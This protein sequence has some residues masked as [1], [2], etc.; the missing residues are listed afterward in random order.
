MFTENLC[1][2]SKIFYSFSTSHKLVTAPLQKTSGEANG[3]IKSSSSLS[4]SRKFLN[5]QNDQI[6][7]ISVTR[8]D[9]DISS[10]LS[11]AT[12]SKPRSYIQMTDFAL[13]SRKSRR[14]GIWAPTSSISLFVAEISKFI[15]KRLQTLE[16]PNLMNCR[17]LLTSSFAL[18]GIMSRLSI[19]KVIKRSYWSFYIGKQ[20]IV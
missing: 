9:L 15:F 5:W 19:Q 11:P 20:N 10:A 18:A 1:S 17:F 16:K 2:R 4:I 8:V 6:E 13:V 7:T 14:P 12:T 3:F